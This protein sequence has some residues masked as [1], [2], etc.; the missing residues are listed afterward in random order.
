MSTQAII[1]KIAVPY[2]K[3]LLEL[4]KNSNLLH[5]T[6]QDLSVISTTLSKSKD[7]QLFLNNPLTKTLTKKNVLNELFKNQVND[8]VLKFLLVLVDR[9]RIFLLMTIINKYL[10]LSNKLESIIIA[11]LSTA[12]EFNETQQHHLIESI[13]LITKSKY[14]KLTMNI[15]TNLIG[16]FCV[17]IGSKVIDSSLNG[18]LRQMSFYLNTIQ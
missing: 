13:K 6:T 17:K 8:S 16:G 2:A 4:S 9:R 18:K 3:A 15:D 11:E 7:L 10:E 14:V 1:N 12:V 5:E